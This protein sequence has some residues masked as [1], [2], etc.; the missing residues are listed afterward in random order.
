MLCWGS[1][2][3]SC[4][5]GG[6]TLGLCRHDMLSMGEVIKALPSSFFQSRQSTGR[7]GVGNRDGCRKRDTQLADHLASGVPAA[8]DPPQRAS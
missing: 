7:H 6:R 5:D 8:Q 4:D 2:V 1:G 3:L